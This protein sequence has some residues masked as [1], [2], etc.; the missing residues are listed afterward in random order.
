MRLGKTIQELL[1]TPFRN[2]GHVL[3]DRLLRSCKR[4]VGTAGLTDESVCPT[5]ARIGLRLWGQSPSPANRLSHRLLTRAAPFGEWSSEIRDRT[6]RDPAVF[7]AVHV[8]GGPTLFW[9][10]L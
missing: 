7:G 8:Q 4:I 5:L 1:S 2:F 10:R 9:K 3:P 6:W